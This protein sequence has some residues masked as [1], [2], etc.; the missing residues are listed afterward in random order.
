MASPGDK[1]GQRRGLCGH[2]MASFDL[3]KRCARCRDKGIGDDDCVAKR[4]CVICDG[5]T[6][7]QKDMLATPMYK[8]RKDKKVFWYLWIK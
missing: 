5:F 2:I 8:I 4:S 1:K 7:T 3:H 6:D